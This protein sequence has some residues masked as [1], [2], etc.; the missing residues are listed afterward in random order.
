[1]TDYKLVVAGGNGVGKSALVIQ[2]IQGTFVADHD[3]TLEDSYLKNAAIDDEPCL[4]NI[5]DTA[6]GEE[7]GALRETFIRAGQ[8]FV[9]VYSVSSR[10]SFDE[11]SPIIKKVLKMREG[12]HASFILVGNKCDVGEGERQV[13]I[14]EG[15][16]LAR[17]F[18]C[19]FFE[20]SAKTNTN[21]EDAF[22]DLVREIR[23]QALVERLSAPPLPKTRCF[24]VI[25]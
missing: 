17:S 19:P 15:Q 11:I 4:L 21:V 10:S 24:C 20:T 14:E 3:P 2:L 5:L 23:K 12:D 7:F 16:A 8:G 25:S 9:F 22:F 18:G 13:T 6:G 1:M